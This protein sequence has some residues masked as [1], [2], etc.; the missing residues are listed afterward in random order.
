MVENAALSKQLVVST[1]GSF[2]VRSF[3]ET[4]PP[5]SA[6]IESWESYA[7]GQTSNFNGGTGYNGSWL[8]NQRIVLVASESWDAYADGQTSDFNLGYGFTDPYWTI[9]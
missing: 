4:G 2:S 1:G 5:A 8:T 9:S 7:V 6:S 3:V